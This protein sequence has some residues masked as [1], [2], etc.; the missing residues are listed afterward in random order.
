MDF[1]SSGY[2]QMRPLPGVTKMGQ[3]I[4]RPCRTAG[5][6]GGWTTKERCRN[7][8]LWSDFLHPYNEK[9]QPINQ[10]PPNGTTAWPNNNR[11]INFPTKRKQLVNKKPDAAFRYMG[12]CLLF[13]QLVT[14]ERR[15]RLSE[16][17]RQLRIQAHGAWLW[18]ACFCGI[19]SELLQRLR[20]LRCR[21]RP[22]IDGKRTQFR[23]VWLYDDRGAEKVRFIKP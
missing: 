2:Y 11:P 20:L 10:P 19:L 23:G 5:S 18:R 12:R 9:G 3:H 7:P 16:P 22:R 4:F 15:E 8:G 1:T 14:A 13:E 21:P 6:C 17:G